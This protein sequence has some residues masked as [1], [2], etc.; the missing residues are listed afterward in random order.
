MG[1]EGYLAEGNDK[2][3]HYDGDVSWPDTPHCSRVHPRR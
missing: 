1:P 3:F 2:G